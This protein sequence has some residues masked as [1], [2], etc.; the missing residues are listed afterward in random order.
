MPGQVTKI[1]KLSERE[2]DR[3][4]INLIFLRGVSVRNELVMDSGSKGHVW[5]PL[6]PANVGC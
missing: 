5:R 4:N 6:G 1:L 3:F 2:R